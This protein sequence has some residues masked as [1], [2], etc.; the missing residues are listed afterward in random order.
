MRHLLKK[1]KLYTKLGPETEHKA[2]ISIHIYLEM[3]LATSNPHILTLFHPLWENRNDSKSYVLVVPMTMSFKVLKYFSSG[4]TSFFFYL[5]SCVV[6]KSQT[7]KIVFCFK[8]LELHNSK[9]F[10]QKKV[11][12]CDWNLPYLEASRT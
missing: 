2:P 7:D 1:L 9:L 3:P 8:N 4:K 5:L 10:S 6:R 11:L 12:V